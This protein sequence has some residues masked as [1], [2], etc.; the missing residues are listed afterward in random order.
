VLSLR[1]LDESQWLGFEE[2]LMGNFRIFLEILIRI[3]IA[4]SNRRVKMS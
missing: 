1:S 3:R 4:K 2:K